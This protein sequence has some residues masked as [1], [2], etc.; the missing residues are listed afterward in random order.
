LVRPE[1]SEK[2]G[3]AARFRTLQSAKK[4]K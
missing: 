3:W 2:T 4:G 1:Q